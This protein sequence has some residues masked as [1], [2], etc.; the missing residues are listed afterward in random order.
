MFMPSITIIGISSPR[1]DTQK[2][3]IAN[4][5]ADY[6]YFFSPS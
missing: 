6:N 3:I 1:Q 2:S 4:T 5:I